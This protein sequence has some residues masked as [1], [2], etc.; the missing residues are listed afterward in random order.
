MLLRFDCGWLHCQTATPIGP[1]GG[2][3]ALLAELIKGH[4]V[5]T[6]AVEDKWRRE[7]SVRGD[8]ARLGLPAVSSGSLCLFFWGGTLK[9]PS[10]FCVFFLVP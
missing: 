8:R 3:G 4:R 7:F 2:L 6:K 5:K 1:R 9:G 10:F